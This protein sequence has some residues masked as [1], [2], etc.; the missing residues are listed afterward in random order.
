MEPIDGFNV[1]IL[2]VFVDAVME[3][4]GRRFI[5][6]PGL[7]LLLAIFAF[8]TV[9]IILVLTALVFALAGAPRAFALGFMT[10]QRNMGLMLAANARDL[11][12][13]SLPV[14]DLY[15]ATTFEAPRP[16][17]GKRTWD[18]NGST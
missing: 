12:D 16:S 10:S 4:V 6:E 5:A 1:I 14:S 8:G 3:N 7:M 11:P 9:L 17:G 18:H 13:F 15:A 2:F